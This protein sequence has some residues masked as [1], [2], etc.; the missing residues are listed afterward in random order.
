MGMYG[1]LR[2]VTPA[3]LSG[4]LKDPDA[5]YQGFTRIKQSA[6]DRVAAAIGKDA[7]KAYGDI[8]ATVHA[9]ASFKKMQEIYLQAGELLGKGQLTLEEFNQRIASAQQ[10]F[11]REMDAVI[12]PA[13]QALRQNPALRASIEAAKNSSV[14][15]FPADLTEIDLQKSWHCLN[16]I[17]TGTASLEDPAAEQSPILGGRPIPD[18][19]DTMGYGPVRYFSAEEVAATLQQLSTFPWA[20]R[21]AA[22]DPGTAE[23]LDVYVPDHG[24][25]ELQYYSQLLMRLFEDAARKGNAVLSWVD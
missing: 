18:R 4:Y 22:Y 15:E 21:I 23:S 6:S 24:A 16:Y 3:D 5:F 2:Q 1:R 13:M 25:D 19:K 11:Q 12:E 9:S 20:R 10:Q 17:L 14:A 7:A 8:R